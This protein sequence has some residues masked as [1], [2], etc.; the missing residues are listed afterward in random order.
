MSC[1]WD[2]YVQI[3]QTDSPEV[4][5]T[6]KAYNQLFISACLHSLAAPRGGGTDHGDSDGQKEGGRDI[7]TQT[8]NKNVKCKSVRREQRESR[9][10][11]KER[12]Q[13]CQRESERE[14][15]SE[16]VNKSKTHNEIMSLEV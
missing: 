2:N 7:H 16:G 1:Y 5:G 10:S 11:T 6:F 8:Q 12:E 9:E 4:P 3:K 13:E 15:E 14:A